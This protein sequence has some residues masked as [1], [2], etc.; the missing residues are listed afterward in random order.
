MV[1]RTLSFR[2]KP[3]MQRSMSSDRPLGPIPVVARSLS[4]RRTLRHSGSS[5][6]SLDGG[7]SVSSM[8]PEQVRKGQRRGIGGRGPPVGNSSFRLSF[9]SS[10]LSGG[11]GGDNSSLHGSSQHSFQ[12]HDSF[13]KLNDSFRATILN[14][15]SPTSKVS[16]TTSN[17]RL[18]FLLA[19]LLIAGLCV[20]NIYVQASM[21]RHVRVDDQGGETEQK[22]LNNTPS[23]HSTLDDFGPEMTGFLENDVRHAPPVFPVFEFASNN[24]QLEQ[25]AT[26]YGLES[27]GQAI[28]A[29][30]E[31]P[32]NDTVPGTGSRSHPDD[33]KYGAPPEFRLP[34]PLRTHSPRVLRKIV[35]PHARTCQDIPH[36]LPI[37]RGLQIDP[38]TGLAVAWNS[39]KSAKPIDYADEEAKYCPVELD[40][41]L[42]WYVS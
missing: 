6:E 3:P 38:E 26:D 15:S 5:F 34:L 36:K 9:R 28:T 7:Q 2:K 23:S 1:N 22:V 32:L 25:Y 13:S 10:A 21:Y 29:F 14:N 42:P 24:L 8:E 16:S 4:T 39:G 27:I 40:P 33:P 31:P 35:Y 30:I 12:L 18:V 37:D 20:I 19:S 41:F 11:A 17:P